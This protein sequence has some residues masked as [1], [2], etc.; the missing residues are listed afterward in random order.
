MNTAP[1]LQALELR[2]DRVPDP[3]QFPFSLPIVQDLHVEFT[4]PVTFLVG[5]NGSGKSTLMEAIAECCD[6]P[7]S[8]GGRN[9]LGT[10]TGPHA[11][12]ELSPAL[13]ASFR[14]KPRDGYFFRAEFHSFFAS[15]LDDRKADPHFPKGSDPYARYGG[16]SL[17]QRSHG[18]AF[19]AMLAAWMQPGIVLMDEPESALSPQR[20]LALL[21]GMARAVAKGDVQMIIATHS[22]IL[23]TFPGAT[24]LSLDGARMEPI[25]LEA[26]SHYRITKSILEAPERFWKHLASPED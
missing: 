8:G 11:A 10:N 3:E 1:Y 13:E 21:A 14:R 2:P 18:E 25:A 19:L 16:K 24:I 6:L 15:L 7:V 5:E 17:H 9:E 23:L 12:S 22:P 26:T 20:Q 4:T